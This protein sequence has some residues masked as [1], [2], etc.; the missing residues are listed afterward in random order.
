VRR[1]L[2]EGKRVVFVS[3]RGNISRS[4]CRDKLARMGLDV[5]A[6]TLLLT[7]TAA[8]MYL[9]ERDPSAAVW[10]LGERGL[11]EEL[12]TFGIRH[13]ERP[14]AAGWL[15]ITLHETVTYRDLNLAFRAVR[16]GARILATNDD[17]VFPAADGD[18]LDVAGMIGAVCY[19]AGKWPE[20]VIGKPSAWMAEAALRTLGLP[21][22]RCLVVGDSLRSD[23]A[24]AKQNGMA[25]A[26]VL[27]GLTD[28]AN[29]FS[30]EYK[31]DYV[32][33]SLAHLF[34]GTGGE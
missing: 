17:R 32:L 6:D 10:T 13:A 34:D 23:V 4:M 2:R 8:G 31:P 15:V 16:N 33:E 25:A 27:T 14:E 3:N 18:A 5:P 22:E 11:R 24:L 19:P 9:R 30:G 29:A 20:V 21:P 7:S 28:R 12:E 1:L 26:L